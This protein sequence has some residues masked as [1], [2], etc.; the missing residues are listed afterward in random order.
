VENHV[1]LHG[2][3]YE[4]RSSVPENDTPMKFETGRTQGALGGAW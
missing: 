1:Y 4:V 2:D 3:R